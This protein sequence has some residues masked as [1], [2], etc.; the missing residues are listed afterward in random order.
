M[1]MEYEKTKT[2]KQ[3]E[4]L[5][6]KVQN[7]YCR[8][9]GRDELRKDVRLTLEIVTGVTPV[10]EKALCFKLTDDEDPFFYYI[11]RLNEDDFKTLKSQQGLLVDFHNFP[12]QLALLL[13]QCSGGKEN[14]KFVLI[15]E[16]DNSNP[17]LRALQIVEKNEFKHLCHLMLCVG[18][19]S[20]D[21][22][23]Q[24][25]ANQIQSLK[26][27]KSRCDKNLSHLESSL[28]H[29]QS[30]LKQKCIELEEM[31][32]KWSEEKNDMH[33]DHLNALREERERLSREQ[34]Q[35]QRD[36]QRQQQELER[37]HTEVVASLESQ[38]SELKTMSQTNFDK[39]CQANTKSKEMKEELLKRQQD[40]ALLQNEL[41][42][43]RK[44]SAELDRDYHEKEIKSSQLQ[45]QNVML[46]E[47]LREKSE[48]ITKLQ[49]QIAQLSSL[50]KDLDNRIE[51]REDVLKKKSSAVET[52]SKDLM[53]ANEILGRL[54]KQHAE[55]SSK[56]KLRTKIS[57]EQEKVI[58]RKEGEVSELRNEIKKL[59]EQCKKNEE[60][61]K[62]LRETLAVTSQKLEERE[63]TLQ[64][65]NNVIS[66]LNR[67]LNELQQQQQKKN[68]TSS[69]PPQYSTSTPIDPRGWIRTPHE[70]RGQ[71]SVTQDPI[72]IPRP[73]SDLRGQIQ[74]TLSQQDKN[75]R[76]RPPVMPQGIFSKPPS[77]NTTG[78]GRP[79]TAPIITS[80]ESKGL[81]DNPAIKNPATKN[82]VTKNPVKPPLPR[83]FVPPASAYFTKPFKN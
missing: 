30:D 63:K 71:Q 77:S 80:V 62:E 58:E 35:W 11:L 53:K 23:K 14:E 68:P 18:H 34:L 50:K 1:R 42:A 31:R 25:M 37:R 5:Y 19:G 22:I 47:E 12:S 16:D 69:T 44:Q 64:N 7:V 72:H 28:M 57:I 59:E 36:H 76:P 45:T 29:I 6:S 56:L 3:S 74:H 21:E 17:M 65:N 8:K 49:E 67:R 9:K 48:I 60:T 27:N 13:Q 61:E 83:P 79:R 10:R 33:I 54:Q 2:N 75:D 73:I 52:L 81:N 40:I 78:D 51:E 55:T 24:Y 43:A 41:V 26:E 38:I 39:L 4:T 15:L 82:P 20:N 46:K 70:I 66:W 32:R